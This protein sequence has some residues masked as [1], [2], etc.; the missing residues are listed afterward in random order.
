MDEGIGTIIEMASPGVNILFSA[1]GALAVLG[2]M[3]AVAVAVLSVVRAFR[4]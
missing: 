4:D 1:L 3:A 2:A